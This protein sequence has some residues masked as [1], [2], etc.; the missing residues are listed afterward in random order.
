M[1]LKQLP[2]DELKIDRAFIKD[3]DQNSKDELILESI[4]KL[5]TN[6]G[7][8]VTAEGVETEFQKDVLTRLGC[9]QLQGFL[10]GMPM[11]IDEL[12]QLKNTP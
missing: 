3:L 4:I 10:L 5:A 6:L 1:Y 8:T 9:H 2:V 11:P 7:L 12:E